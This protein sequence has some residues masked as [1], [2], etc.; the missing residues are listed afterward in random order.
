MIILIE[1]VVVS[2]AAFYAYRHFE[3]RQMDKQIAQIKAQI[4]GMQQDL[5][6][7]SKVEAR[8]GEI[9]SLIAEARAIES[10]DLSPGRILR[11][12][13]GVLPQDTWLSGLKV[14]PT[15]QISLDGSTFALES[16]ARTALILEDSHLFEKVRV[17][18][19]RLRQVND[20]SVYDFSMQMGLQPGR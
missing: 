13:R 14:D 9:Q 15:G 4:A 17:S 5:D 10:E 11:E 1:V 2:A 18:S 3:I 19:M 16:V 20:T 12:I 7:L 8:N 6:L